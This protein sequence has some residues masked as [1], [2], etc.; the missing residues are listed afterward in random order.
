MF[1]ID[2]IVKS[3]SKKYNDPNRKQPE[4]TIHVTPKGGMYVDT[5]ELLESESAKKHIE[6]FRRTH[7]VQKSANKTE[8]EHKRIILP[9]YH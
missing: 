8:E 4:V 2:A 3:F 5:K 9:P 1:V 7:Q 6:D